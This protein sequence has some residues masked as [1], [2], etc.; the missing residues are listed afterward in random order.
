VRAVI[1]QFASMAKARVPKNQSNRNMDAAFLR[2]N[3]SK[4]AT[5]KIWIAANR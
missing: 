5:A 3:A 4:N 2:L 1:A